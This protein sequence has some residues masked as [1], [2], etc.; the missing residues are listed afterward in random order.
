MGGNA[1]HREARAG[2]AL[3]GYI[4]GGWPVEVEDDAFT[5]PFSAPS[6]G[7]PPWYLYHF[8]STPLSE[9]R[10]KSRYGATRWRFER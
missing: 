2:A 4:K 7:P 10:A 9:S 8:S 3:A 1:S 5:G 6:A